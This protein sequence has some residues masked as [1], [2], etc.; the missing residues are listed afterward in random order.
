MKGIIIKGIGGFYYV[1]DADSTVYECKAR[2]IFRKNN[3]KPTVG[4]YVEF[5]NGSI[6]EIYPR[7]SHLIRPSV[8]NIDNLP[9][10]IT[11]FVT[12]K[13]IPYKIVI[14]FQDAACMIKAS[15]LE[16]KNGKATGSLTIMFGGFNGIEQLNYASAISGAQEGS[17]TFT[18]K[19]DR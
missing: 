7:K 14:E 6:N 8:A 1:K 4:D 3:I 19:V 5:E 12:E 10:D 18:D 15:T 2:G 11:I 13:Y 9:L 16:A 17:Y